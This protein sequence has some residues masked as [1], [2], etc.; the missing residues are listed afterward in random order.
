ML[1]HSCNRSDEPPSG[2]AARRRHGLV[3]G[4]LALLISLAWTPQAAMGQDAGARQIDFIHLGGNDCPPCVVWRQEELPK[5]QAMPE[6]RDVR[7][8]LVTKTIRSPVPWAVFFPSEIRHL[9]PALVEA[10]GGL[11]GSP[12]QALLVNG[13]VVDYRR[14]SAS[15]QDIRDMIVALRKGEPP[16]RPTCAR[17]GPGW[18]CLQ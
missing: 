16:P 13:Q 9:Q 10:S 6:M 2:C 18:Q 12:Q 4:T 3:A 11:S 8:S 15:A 1:R 5:L 14:G 7:I 17:R